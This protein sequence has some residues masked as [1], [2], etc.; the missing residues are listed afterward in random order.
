MSALEV[1]L[2]PARLEHLEAWVAIRASPTAR[3][4]VAMEKDSREALLQRL[5]EASG[6]VKDPRATSFRWMVEAQGRIVGTVSAREL[7]RMHGRVEIGYMIAE[8]FIGRGIGTRAVGMM[9]E[10]LFSISSLHRVWLSTAAE[11]MGSQGVARKLGFTLEGVLRGHYVVQGRR[12]DKQVWGL[13]R[14][15]WE[16]RHEAR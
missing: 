15:E 14:P 7:S 13:L 6:D 5:R 4:L 9:L 2:V 3:R 11:N 8:E 1:G 12:M 16:A 10:R